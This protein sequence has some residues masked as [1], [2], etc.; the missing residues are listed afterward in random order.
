MTTPPIS[1]ESQRAVTRERLRLLSLGYYISG[2]IGAVCVSFLL[3]HLTVFTVLSFIPESKW[4]KNA[5]SVTAPIS[6]NEQIA[7]PHEVHSD[8]PPVIIFR[9]A[10]G[11]IGFIILVGWTL[12][13]LTIYAGRCI[14]MRKQRTFV[15]V[16]AGMNCI[17]IP[18]GTLLGVAT[19]LTLSTPDAKEEWPG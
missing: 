18:Y 15:H 2:A 13:G 5:R 10:A 14:K 7:K 11:V 12:G 16:I 17:W 6:Q 3:I 4:N 8:A 9:I 19:F 1:T